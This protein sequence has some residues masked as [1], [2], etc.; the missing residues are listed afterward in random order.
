VTLVWE[1]AEELDSLPAIRS[2]QKRDVH[3]A[4]LRPSEKRSKQM[5][6]RETGL[7]IPAR[8]FFS[9]LVDKHHDRRGREG[10]S[11]QTRVLGLHIGVSAR[12]AWTRW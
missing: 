1:T 5:C 9:G 10:T 12:R 8:T 11:G 3:T 6:C 4:A 2:T 7:R